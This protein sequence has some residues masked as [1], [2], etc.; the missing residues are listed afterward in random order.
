[1]DI[2]PKLNKKKILLISIKNKKDNCIMGIRQHQIIP[3]KIKKLIIKE[4]KI[5]N[6]NR[7]K[8][9]INVKRNLRKVKVKVILKLI[10]KVKA[11]IVS[12]ILIII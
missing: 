6:Y 10:V 7:Q 9:L 5:I 1:V 8:K 11:R 2:S 12:I 4:I 3:R